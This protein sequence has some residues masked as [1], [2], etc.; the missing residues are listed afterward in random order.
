MDAIEQTVAVQSSDRRSRT[1]IRAA[2]E[3]N[4][5]AP[6]RPCRVI[7]SVMLRASSR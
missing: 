7:T 6:S 1:T 2:G 4:S 3:T 5:T